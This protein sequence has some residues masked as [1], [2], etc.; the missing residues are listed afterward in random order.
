[1]RVPSAIAVPCIRYYHWHHCL[2]PGTRVA[3]LG[4][5]VRFFYAGK[6]ELG[7]YMCSR[8]MHTGYPGTIVQVDESMCCFRPSG[9]G[10]FLGA[11]SLP[12][13]ANGAR[14]LHDWAGH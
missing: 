8:G 9:N 11:M 14:A 10:F 7:G 1:M 3:V 6:R 2:Y 5:P 4:Y 13:L 12:G